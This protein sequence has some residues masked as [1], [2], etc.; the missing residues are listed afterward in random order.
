MTGSLAGNKER[1]PIVAKPDQYSAAE[2]SVRVIASTEADAGAE[3]ATLEDEA[4]LRLDALFDELLELETGT[5]AVD[6]LLA[7]LLELVTALET[8]DEAN[9]LLCD[10]A[11]AED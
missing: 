10:E 8:E 6:E 7:A 5:L 4:L 11:A 3:L 1:S 2:V 9:E